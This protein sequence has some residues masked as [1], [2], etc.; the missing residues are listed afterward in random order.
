V[1][2]FPA[3]LTPT[4]APPPPIPQ[5][6]AAHPLTILEIGD[7][8][9]EDLG[10]GM[11][12]VLG[13]D[14]RVRVL[15]EAVGDTG[16]ARPDYYDWAVHLEEELATYHPGVVVVMLGGNDGQSF[17]A[18]GSYVGFGTSEWHTIYSERV[19]QVMDEATKAGAHVLWVGMPIMQDAAFSATMET[20]NSVYEQQAADH[21]GVT[22]FPS[23]NVFTNA[24]G[25]YASEL[26]DA[27]GQL[28]L[29]RDSDGIHIA[30]GGCTRLASAIVPAMDAAWGI[31]L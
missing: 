11:G 28:V 24:A 6:S 2:T 14:P 17:D 31:H 3:V 5:P 10:I 18:N 19:A 29:V 25:G 9:G 22:W 13:S 12:G 4:T 7:S 21:A 15:Q 16:L 20:L 1:T 23:W 26:P 8:L 27:S 30:Y